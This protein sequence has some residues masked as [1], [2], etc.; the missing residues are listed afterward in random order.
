MTT[1]I[2]TFDRTHTGFL[3]GR[4][5]R[6]VK[7]F[8]L[9]IGAILVIKQVFTSDVI[10]EGIQV[11]LLDGEIRF[12][13][14]FGG[15]EGG[16]FSETIPIRPRNAMVSR[17]QPYYT[18]TTSFTAGGTLTGGSVSDL[19]LAKTA[20]IST[21]IVSIGGVESH[22]RGAPPGTYY[23]RLTAVSAAK[24]IIRVAWDEEV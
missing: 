16:A 1:S 21:S 6:I 15:T 11:D 14:V 12:E 3:A 22:G 2:N 19:I 7:E 8:D 5:F 23:F 9:S 4:E 24:G 10:I 13:N 20:N 18:S 17:P